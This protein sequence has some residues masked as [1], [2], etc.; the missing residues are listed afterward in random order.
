MYYYEPKNTKVA[1][2]SI[3]RCE[4]NHPGFNSKDFKTYFSYCKTYEG[5]TYMDRDC[6]EEGCVKTY[7]GENYFDMTSRKG[8]LMMYT[9]SFNIKKASLNNGVFNNLKTLSGDKKF[10][11]TDKFFDPNDIFAYQEGCG[12]MKWS[13]GVTEKQ[14]ANISYLDIQL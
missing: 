14:K 8:W 7:T 5:N 9:H 6:Y 4:L 2:I 10:P 12:L 13:T 3:Q 1:N 11:L